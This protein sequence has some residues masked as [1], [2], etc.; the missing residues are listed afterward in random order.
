MCMQSIS[1]IDAI[2]ELALHCLWHADDAINCT[3]VCMCVYSFLINVDIHIL[4]HSLT[5]GSS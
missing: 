1:V 2:V 5:A 3:Y 4:K